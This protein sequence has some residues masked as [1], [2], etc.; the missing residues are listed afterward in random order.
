MAL[1]HNPA[2]FYDLFGPTKTALKG[3]SASV[4]YEK[5]LVYDKPREMHLI[6]DLS[7]YTGLDRLPRYQNIDATFDTLTTFGARIDYTRVRKSLGAVDDEKGF[8]WTLGATADHVDGDT[9]PKVLAEFDF[10]FALPW[11][12]SSIWLRNSV[13]AAF[14]DPLDEFANFFFGGFGNNF[15]DHG[16]IKRYRKYY[17]MPGFDLN[18]VP[19]RNFHRAMLEWTLP[20]IRFRNVGGSKFYLS[21]ARTAL[22]VSTLTTNFESST[23]RQEVSSAGLQIDFQF[24]ILSRLDMT[25][26]LGYAKGFGNSLI[27]DDDEFMVSL[28]VL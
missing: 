15:V 23:L 17:A 1:R 13:G 22:F 20:P 8:T 4:T 28:K 12:H 18:A 3:Q 7:H 25:L 10:G 6:V 11:K 19:G 24:T 2:D 26:S 14:G 9:I 27:M 5:T 16:E 21:W